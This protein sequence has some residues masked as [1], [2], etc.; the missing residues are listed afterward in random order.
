MHPAEREIEVQ[1]AGDASLF[2]YV[3]RLLAGL[4]DAR[5]ERVTRKAGQ[6]LV[7]LAVELCGAVL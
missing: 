7:E 1:R 3:V 6:D 2:E 4:G 5:A